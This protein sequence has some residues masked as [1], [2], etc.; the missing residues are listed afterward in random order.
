[1]RREKKLLNGAQGRRKFVLFFYFFCLTI[2]FQSGK[3]NK[4]NFSNISKI[5]M[6]TE[7]KSKETGS[8]E[9]DVLAGDERSHE[10]TDTDIKAGATKKEDRRPEESPAVVLNSLME[11]KIKIEKRLSSAEELSEKD[12]K[13]LLQDKKEISWQIVRQYC[14]IPPKKD[15]NREKE[16]I[17]SEEEKQLRLSLDA[18]LG[19]EI[20][21]RQEAQEQ[22]KFAKPENLNAKYNEILNNTLSEKQKRELREEGSL[23]VSSWPATIEMN[24]EDLAVAAWMGLDINKIKQKGWLPMLSKKIKVGDKVFES[25]ADFNEKLAEG[26]K[27]YIESQVRNKIEEQKKTTI[28]DSIEQTVLNIEI[29]RIRIEEE[30]KAWQNLSQEDQIKLLKTTEDKF[31]EIHKLRQNTEN[32]ENKTNQI[33]KLSD[34]IRMAAEEISGRDL[35]QD[36]LRATGYKLGS[37]GP[38]QAEFQKYLSEQTIEILKNKGN[39]FNEIK[40]AKSK[41]RTEIK[42]VPEVVI[43]EII[44]EKITPTEIPVQERV[45]EVEPISTASEKVQ[46]PEK[47]TPEIIP[48]KILREV[49]PAGNPI[50]EISSDISPKQERQQGGKKVA[51]KSETESGAEKMVTDKGKDERGKELL[52][53]AEAAKIPAKEWNEMGI[54]WNAVNS[55]KE[56]TFAELEEVSKKIRE[57]IL[58][59][60]GTLAQDVNKPEEKKEEPQ[61]RISKP[62]EAE[63]KVPISSDTDYTDKLDLS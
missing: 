33:R 21:R 30:N 39:E 7:I 26:K 38:K 59:N 13:A 57:I 2:I 28:N 55:K 62:A 37:N 43:P 45:P 31:S 46:P 32:S 36:A 34:E 49:G 44:A 23:V 15:F 16:R 29:N 10:Q 4:H 18:I 61:E 24:G 54:L 9:A 35:I 58:K 53:E 1:M 41:E 52:A 25:I 17:L 6:S 12:K 5:I 63:C 60:K 51:G 48:V 27:K 8:E 22:Q 19:S 56:V 50:Q 42:A 14:E 11:E 40:K 20:I 47:L 3:I